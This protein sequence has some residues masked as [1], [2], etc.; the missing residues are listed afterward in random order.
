MRDSNQIKRRALSAE[1]SRA[2]EP[3]LEAVA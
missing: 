2:G 1:R 3:E